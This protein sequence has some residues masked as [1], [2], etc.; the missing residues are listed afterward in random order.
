MIHQF[1]QRLD[2]KTEQL[3]HTTHHFLTFQAEKLKSL[4][5]LLDSYSYQNVLKRGFSLTQ[6]N[7]G[8]LISS[9]QQAQNFSQFNILF[10]DGKMSVIPLNKKKILKQESTQQQGD[11]FK[12]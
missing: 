3:I 9:I 12:E 1:T 7:N 6:A 11:L 8:Q 2:D 10:Y 5:R 4:S